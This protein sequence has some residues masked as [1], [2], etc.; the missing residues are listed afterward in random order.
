M[1]CSVDL[2]AVQSM[3]IPIKIDLNKRWKWNLGIWL[4][5][6][7]FASSI[8]LQPSRTKPLNNLQNQWNCSRKLPQQFTSPPL[9]PGWIAKE[10]GSEPSEKFS[11]HA[12]CLV[13]SFVSC[14]YF[15]SYFSLVVWNISIQIP[16]VTNFTALNSVFK[17]K[18]F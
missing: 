9:R 7:G 4:K 8:P 14:F 10:S 5:A 12:F 16:L 3:D 13:F 11:S 2:Y 1:R 18:L 6:Q 15:H 17:H